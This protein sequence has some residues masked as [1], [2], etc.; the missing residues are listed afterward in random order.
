MT[1]REYIEKDSRP[2]SLRTENGAAYLMIGDISWLPV[3]EKRLQK[4]KKEKGYK[5]NS[6]KISD[7]EIEKIQE[8]LKNYKQIL[9]REVLEVYD[10]YYGP[11]AVVIEGDE[12]GR[13][14]TEEEFENDRLLELERRNIA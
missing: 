5:L 11:S 1:L 8:Y 14:W 4:A 10:R 6:K 7:E 12:N 2:M 3:I 9:E 13:Y